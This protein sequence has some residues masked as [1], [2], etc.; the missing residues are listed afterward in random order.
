MQRV[1]K[2]CYFALG[3]LF[4]GTG[5]V[6]AFLPVL[7]TTPFM[8]LAL[9]MFAKS[10]QRFHH[11]LYHHPLFGCPLQQWHTHRV[12]P[13]KAK[14]AS[15]TMMSLSFIYML[16]YSPVPWWMDILIGLFMLYGAWFVLSKPSK[17]PSDDCPVTRQEAQL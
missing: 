13:L 14:L 7:P 17:A 3:W 11:W 6:G 5:L 2:S 10:S 9:W 8:L 12:I 4:F 15:V 16:F 1:F